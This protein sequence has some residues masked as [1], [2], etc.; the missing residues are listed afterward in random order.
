MTSLL[1]GARK[2]V[3]RGSDLGGRLE[4]LETAV[5]AAR[6]RLPDDVVDEASEVVDRAGSRLRLSADHTVVALHV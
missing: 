2:L 3:T 5:S 4:A 6:G 1:E